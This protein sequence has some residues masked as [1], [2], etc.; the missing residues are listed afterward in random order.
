MLLFRHG[1]QNQSAGCCIDA[2][3]SKNLTQSA[4]STGN[5][6]IVKS[7]RGMFPRR[8][9]EWIEEEPNYEGSHAD[10][11]RC[12]CTF[13]RFS[14]RPLNEPF[15]DMTFGR[16]PSAGSGPVGVTWSCRALRGA[17]ARSGPSTHRKPTMQQRKPPMRKTL[18]T[19]TALAMACG[20]HRRCPGSGT[21]TWYRAQRKR[22]KWAS[23]EVRRSDSARFHTDIQRR[24][25]RCRAR[26][27]AA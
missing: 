24:P 20:W 4:G 16:V 7:C 12:R 8:F 5:V 2:T 10:D 27:M 26:P 17:A 11:C 21:R 6:T 18:L 15:R 23:P 3:Q 22:R 14:L 13:V 25:S 9:E 1:I 19:T